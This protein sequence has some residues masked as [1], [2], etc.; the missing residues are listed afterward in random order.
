MLTLWVATVGPRMVGGQLTVTF[1]PKLNVVV[2]SK[3][4]N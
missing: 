4:V 2:E 3:A 1:G